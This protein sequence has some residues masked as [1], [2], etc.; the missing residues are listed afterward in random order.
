MI[1][2]RLFNGDIFIYEGYCNLEK[3]NDIKKRYS[4]GSYYI[5]VI[6]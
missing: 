4:F 1:R 3:F 2:Y 5:K 6:S